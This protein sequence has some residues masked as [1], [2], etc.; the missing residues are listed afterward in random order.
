MKYIKSFEDKKQPNRPTHKPVI[1]NY[2]IVSKD[3][4]I[5]KI[6]SSDKETNSYI[7]KI[8][9]DEKF[10]NGKLKYPN[11]KLEFVDRKEI[12]FYTWNQEELEI[13]KNSIKYNI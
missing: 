13:A 11:G 7:V 2:V 12:L 6:I 9:T 4:E 5:G 1:G 10:P 8:I 3:E